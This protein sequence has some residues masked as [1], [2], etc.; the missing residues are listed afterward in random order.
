MH[1]KI[2]LKIKNFYKE[3]RCNTTL[4]T[5]YGASNWIPVTCRKAMFEKGKDF[6]GAW[7]FGP[8]TKQN[9]KVLKLVKLIKERMKSSSKI[10]IR[11]N[12]KRLHNKNIK[13]IQVFKYRQS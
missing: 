3:S 5:C 8:S 9:M 1:L 11:R 6:A 2:F 7:N 4:A 10:I 12:D 13:R